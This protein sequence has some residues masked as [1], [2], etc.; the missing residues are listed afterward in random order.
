MCP[1][2]AMAPLR[3]FLSSL[4]SMGSLDHKLPQGALHYAGIKT[5]T[6]LYSL[7]KG[8]FGPG[9]QSGKHAC[10]RPLIF[11]EYFNCILNF[12]HFVEL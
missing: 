7:D 8:A 3:S 10:H 9:R 1:V 2:G 5:N 6:L 4:W 12:E 11:N